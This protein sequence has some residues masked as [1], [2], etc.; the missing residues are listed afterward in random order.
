MCV[1][2]GDWRGQLR[3]WGAHSSIL[4]G[5]SQPDSVPTMVTISEVQKVYVFSVIQVL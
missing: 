4:L 5:H 1:G 2:M 3:A